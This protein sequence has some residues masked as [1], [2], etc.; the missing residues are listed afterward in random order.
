MKHNIIKTENYLLVVD[1]SEIK[2]GDWIYNKE[3]EPSILQC[4][5]KGSLR[6]WSKIIAHLPLN[7]S[8]ILEGV[9]L[10]PPLE[11]EIIGKPLDNYIRERHNQD[12]C[13]GFID[14]YNK[15]KEKYKYTE[16]DLFQ[17]VIKARDGYFSSFNTC[18][19]EIKQ[20]L[21]QP[22]MPIA[23]ECEMIFK[24]INHASGLEPT[25]HPLMDKSILENYKPK[26]TTN[27]NGQIVWVGKYLH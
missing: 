2:A 20:S 13:V 12:E 26:A 7:N 11:D 25:G 19:D 17:A 23:F 27:S 16:A 3:R 4:M 1:D 6:G 9:P 21:Q 8:P 18:F 24:P 22:K 5:G 14:G 15:A 10:L